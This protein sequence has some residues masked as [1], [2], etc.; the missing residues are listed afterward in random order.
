[1]AEYKRQ[2]LNYEIYDF[3]SIENKLEAMAREGWFL[4]SIGALTL[5]YKK[6]EP[7][8]VSYSAVY[9]P[10]NSQYQSDK[11]TDQA[12]FNEYL[13]AGGW[14]QVTKF[15]RLY[16]YMSEQESPT[17]IETDEMLKLENINKS[18]TK[19]QVFGNLLLIALFIF[20]LV[21]NGSIK[22][23]SALYSSYLSMALCV[24]L[25]LV[26]VSLA[27]KMIT[28]LIWYRKCVKEQRLISPEK[29]GRFSRIVQN[30][31]LV[32]IIALIFTAFADGDAKIFIMIVVCTAAILAMTS[33]YQKSIKRVRENHSKRFTAVSTTIVLFLAFI[34][35]FG[36]MVFFLI[37]GDVTSDD[38]SAEDAPLNI[39]DLYDV[40]YSSGAV[41]NSDDY[42]IFIDE[43]STVLMSRL[44][45]SEYSSNADLEYTLVK[46]DRNT[47]KNKVVNYIMSNDTYPWFYEWKEVSTKSAND[48]TNWNADKVYIPDT[49]VELESADDNVSIARSYLLVYDDAIL[50]ITFD[51]V[52]TQEMIATVESKL[53][54]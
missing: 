15:D 19:N 24:M 10:K 54:N 27:M 31:L 53:I 28:Y 48:G 3:E 4:D 51:D 34:L 16:I 46:T 22:D 43:S 25:V 1:M 40:D 2:F 49:G 32:A 35:L 14:K 20:N 17:P 30:I 12:E 29:Y 18:Y 45:Y 8:N 50:T 13:A 39:S 5:K 9:R 36:I 44:N 33:I 52:P 11:S 6:G 47:L 23:P 26:I 42:E 7:R 41:Q 21:S 37:I 38:Q